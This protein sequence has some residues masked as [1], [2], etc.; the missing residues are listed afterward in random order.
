MPYS[1]VSSKKPMLSVR[2]VHIYPRGWGNATHRR[3]P[4][5]RQ[6]SHSPEQEIL[7]RH[8]SYYGSVNEGVLNEIASNKWTKALKSASQLAELA[9]QDQP[10]ISF[11]V[12]GQ[13][14]G[15]EAQKMISG[16]T[17][18][19]LAAR[20]T[21]NQVMAHPWWEGAILWRAEGGR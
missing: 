7:T 11:E 15:S 14:L 9:V 3:S 6:A 8:L 2:A 10:E 12:W 13:E 19:D 20:S 4:G 17:K 18:P 16:M 21:T 5:P 1:L